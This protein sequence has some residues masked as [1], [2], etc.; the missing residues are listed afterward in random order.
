[1][2]DTVGFA[3]VRVLI[4]F[5][6]GHSSRSVSVLA[7]YLPDS[8]SGRVAVGEVF[9]LIDQAW[10]SECNGVCVDHVDGGFRTRYC[11]CI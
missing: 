11:I 1:M 9:R 8:A 10:N 7:Q 6:S 3:N 2:L 5:D 4:C